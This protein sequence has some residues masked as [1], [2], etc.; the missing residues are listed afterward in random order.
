MLNQIQCFR[1]FRKFASRLKWKL[2]FCCRILDLDGVEISFVEAKKIDL[3]DDFPGN[4][5]KTN[6]QSPFLYI[7]QKVEI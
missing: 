6:F 3:L 4:Q 7:Q 2:D 1:K 5:Q